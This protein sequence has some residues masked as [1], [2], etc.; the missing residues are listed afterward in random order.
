MEKTG[1]FVNSHCYHC[2]PVTLP[3]SAFAC[4]VSEADEEALCEF[5]CPRCQR[6]LFHAVPAIDFPVLRMLGVGRSQSLPFELLEPHA[7]R[8]VSWDDIL[9]ARLAL[10]H[11]CCPQEEIV[12]GAAA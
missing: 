1:A 4:E 7:G 3:C 6:L 12:H 5:R 11:G 2:G 10:E 9:D 8:P